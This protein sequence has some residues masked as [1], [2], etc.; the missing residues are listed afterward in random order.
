MLAALG[1]TMALAAQPAT[2]ETKPTKQTKTTTSEESTEEAKIDPRASD[3]LRDMTKFLGQ[4]KALSVETE[5]VVEV[6][7]EDGQTLDIPYSSKVLMKRPDKLRVE[8][9]GETKARTLYYDGKLFTLYG[10]DANLYAQAPAPPNLDDAIDTARDRLGIEAPAAD[11]LY[12]DAY[13]GL[14]D[15][16]ESGTYV[17]EEQVDGKAVHH[18]AFRGPEVD[19]QV[20]VAKGDRPL[21][22]RYVISSKTVEGSPDFRVDLSN[23]ELPRSI[24]NDRFAFRAPAG[25]TKIEFLKQ[26]E[27]GTGGA[28][29]Q[30]TGGSPDD[31]DD[32]SDSSGS[33]NNGTSE[34]NQQ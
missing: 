27:Q 33:S 1:S 34:E 18:L 10:K 14:M 26:G 30:G 8:R 7:T 13:E 17:G 9:V 28:G 24:P 19:W 2:G 31:Q 12:A 23:W 21:P 22:L 6:V 32:D 16:V 25:A 4:Q 20:W 5:G 29:D 15:G 11:L 3:V